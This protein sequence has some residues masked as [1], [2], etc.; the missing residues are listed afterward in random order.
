M[1]LTSSGTIG[2]SGSGLISGALLTTNS[3]GGETLN[4]ANAVS[5]FNAT[6]I[7]SGDIALTN[8]AAPLTITGISQTGGGDIIV[9]NSGA[10]T[11]SGAITTG[12]NGNIS[13]TATGGTETLGSAVTANGSGNVTL[14]ATGASSDILF[15][16]N[17]GSTSGVIT[18]T[19]GRNITLNGGNISTSGNVSL[20]GTAGAISEES[21]NYINGALLTTVSATGTT[22]GN[23]NT[24]TSFNATNATGGISLINTAAPL[25]VTGI[26]ETGTGDITVTNSGALTT[27]G[28]IRQDQTAIF[29]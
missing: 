29:H 14:S 22:L 7:T 2:E 25:T 23:A 24:V 11:T 20:T 6:N 8:T 27:S 9:T 5:S 28:A 3:V 13:L 15:N 17:V 4:G 16:A 10:L 1:S 18:A 21:T 26:S 19:A 12:S